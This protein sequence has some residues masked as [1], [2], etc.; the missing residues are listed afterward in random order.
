[1]DVVEPAD[2]LARWKAAVAPILEDY[3]KAATEKGLPGAEFLKDL[4]AKV[5]AN[6]LSASST[7]TW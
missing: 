6:P 3:V 7:D 4:Q 1:M 2:E 5:A